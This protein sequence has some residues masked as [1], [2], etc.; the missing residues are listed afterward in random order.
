MKNNFLKKTIKKNTKTENVEN[1]IIIKKKQTIIITAGGTGGHVFPAHT[2][3]KILSNGY[4]ILF[5]IDC[6]GH[7]FLLQL[8]DFNNDAKTNANDAK[9]YTIILI[10][11]S[12][13]DGTLNQKVLS[14]W[15]LLF[16]TL[17]A[18]Y[19]CART[20]PK[21][22]VGF[23]GYATI[24][25][26]L[27]GYIFKIPI[28]LH[29]QNT[30]LGR[31]NDFFIKIA[32]LVI[33]S[34]PNV[35][36]LNYTKY[37]DKIVNIGNPI[38][39]EIA[40]YKNNKKFVD[41]RNAKSNDTKNNLIKILIIG[42]SQGAGLFNKIPAYINLL[43][44]II[45]N[46]LIVNHQVRKE[47]MDFVINEYKN[48][49]IK[50]YNVSTFFKNI[51]NLMND[52]DLIISRAGALSVSEIEHFGKPAIF[53]PYA[54]AKD[55]HQYYNAKYLEDNNSAIIITESEFEKNF[56]TTLKDL[57]VNNALEKITI[58]AK[59]NKKNNAASVIAVKINQ[60]IL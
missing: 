53:I 31:V 55:N 40:E 23:G 5:C 9:A 41:D 15:K 57:L 20:N 60:L 26:I 22:V 42:G 12:N 30:V 3:A 58:N 28:V 47:S 4:N 38:R 35:L 27:A 45:K 8:N 36:K 33:L 50:E 56:F 7:N 37:R 1:N 34:F 52:A 6:R 49:D 16:G 21:L 10:P 46:K 44:Q 43:P 18:I 19:H 11:S 51:A 14:L 48:Y 13:L 54:L 2:I 59:K 32:K 17:K 24:P 25:C 29:E 39:K